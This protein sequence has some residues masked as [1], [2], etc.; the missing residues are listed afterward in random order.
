MNAPLRLHAT[1]STASGSAVASPPVV[2]LLDR[3]GGPVQGIGVDVVKLA[4]DGSGDLIV[5]CHEALGD[6]RH[7]L[8]VV[9]DGMRVGSAW[10]C[11]LFEE[12]DAPLDVADGVVDLALRPFELV[13]ARLR[14]VDDFDGRTKR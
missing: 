7:A 4:D 11:N 2:R 9:G 3:G 8:L 10:R 1:T 6:R 14:R 13:T 12:P 5:R